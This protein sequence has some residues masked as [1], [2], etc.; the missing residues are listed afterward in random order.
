MCKIAVQF[1][2]SLYEPYGFSTKI[3]S[4][5]ENNEITSSAVVSFEHQITK[6]LKKH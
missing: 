1:N 3:A 6:R 5:T 4:T 2:F